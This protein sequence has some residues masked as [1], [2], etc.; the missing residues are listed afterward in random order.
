MPK[1][2][3]AVRDSCIR[4]VEKDKGRLATEKEVSNCKKLASIWYY[5]K[6][7]KPVEHSNLRA[8]TFDDFEGRSKPKRES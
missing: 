4:K 3:E 7:G 6:H 1:D 8:Q 2:Y 5:K